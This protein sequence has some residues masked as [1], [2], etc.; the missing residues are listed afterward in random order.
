MKKTS[1]LIDPYW[2]QTEPCT[3]TWAQIKV[4]TLAISSQEEIPARL[5]RRKLEDSSIN[6][7][8]F[9]NGIIGS[10][11][12]LVI[13]YSYMSLSK[14]WLCSSA[15]AFVHKHYRHWGASLPQIKNHFITAIN[16][17]LIIPV[18]APKHFSDQWLGSSTLG[19]NTFRQ[20]SRLAQHTFLLCSR[21]CK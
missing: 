18:V 5:M 17:A 20:D 19:R 7:A 14:K 9:H 11:C 8:S 3:F 4:R 1:G 12:S 16:I 2:V 6:D 15:A 10:K 21:H 13:A